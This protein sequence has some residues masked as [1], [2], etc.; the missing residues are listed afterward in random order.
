MSS[1]RNDITGRDTYLMVEALTFTIEAFS[2]LPVEFRPDN[3]I[4]DMKRLL[5]ELVKQDASLAQS[6]VLARRRL[7]NVLTYIRRP[8][9]P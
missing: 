3:N 9:N 1:H 2:G 7:E 6:Q 8:N 4:T 5:G